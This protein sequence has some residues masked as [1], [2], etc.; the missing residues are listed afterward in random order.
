VLIATPNLCLDRT[1]FVSQLVPGAVM[2]ALSVE[3]TAG[4]KGFT[5]ARLV[6][7]HQRPA[8]L[9]GLVADRDRGRLLGLLHEEGAE[10]VDVPMP[11]DARMAMIMVEQLGGRITVLNEPGSTLDAETWDRYLEAV[12]MSL[13]RHRTL[14]CSGSLPPGAPEAGYGQLVELARE[15]GVLALVDSAPAPLRASL[16]SE[17]D[18]VTPNLQEAEAA[19]SGVSGSVLADA[20]EDVRERATEAAVTLCRLGSR[21]AAVTAGA[22]GVAL[23]EGSFGRVR[24]FPAAEV[25][26]VSAV[27]AGDSFLAGV[28]LELERDPSAAAVD[29]GAVMLRGSATASASCEQLRAG[30]VDP[31][32]VEELLARLRD[33]ADLQ[34]EAARWPS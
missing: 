19:I 1:Q 23:A 33:L 32:R 25:E 28:I 31:E 30:G 29:W 4:G 17:P 9:V 14:A 7:A 27:G 34:P 5:I 8:T 12:R 26:V 16:A 18:L 11:G 15:A 22:H 2:R 6:R 10:V 21:N 13:P 24:W 3:V 20:D